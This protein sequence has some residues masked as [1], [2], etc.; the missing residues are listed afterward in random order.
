MAIK[1]KQ[2]GEKWRIVIENEEWEFGTRKE[3]DENLKKIL[4]I[5]DKNGRI[6]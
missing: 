4:D 6:K 3:F 2:H 1:I 5:K